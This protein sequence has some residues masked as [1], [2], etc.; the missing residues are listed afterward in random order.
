MDN[1]QVTYLS[2]LEF[3]DDYTGDGPPRF[4]LRGTGIEGDRHSFSINEP[5][6]KEGKSLWSE[7]F[8]LRAKTIYLPHTDV[9]ISLKYLTG[10]DEQAE[11]LFPPSGSLPDHWE[12]FSIQ[13]NDK[14]YAL[15][16]PLSAFLEDRWKPA[17]EDAGI[18]LAGVDKPYEEYDSEQ[19]SLNNDLGQSIDVTVYN[20][21]AQTLDI[22]QCTV[23]T[24]CVIYGNYDFSGT[25]LRI[26]GGLMP[27]WASREDV[28]KRYG[29]PDQSYMD[30]S[31]TYRETSSG[32]AYWDLT[33]DESGFLDRVILHN[34]EYFSKNP[35]SARSCS[36]G[37]VR[38]ISR[39]FVNGPLVPVP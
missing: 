27:G 25:D 10:L 14:V 31:L 32:A 34:Q 11:E 9:I 12:S 7:N 26:P 3:D 33:F 2:R 19:I 21:T 36:T 16:A 15:P 20:T 24:V 22:T 18:Q 37:K 28:L 5:E 30:H 17:G 35:S 4:Y 13:I 39:V 38:G 23:G 8:D 1:P 6:Y 29:A